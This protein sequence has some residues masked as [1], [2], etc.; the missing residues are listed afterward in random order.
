MI[1][2]LTGDAACADAARVGVTGLSNG[3]GMSAV[4]ACQAADLLAAAAPVA[5]GYSTLP[6]CDP[7]RPLPVLEI[8]GLRDGVVPYI[9]QVP[10]G[11]GAVGPYVDQW[12]VR[13][14]CPNPPRRSAPARNVL[15][16]RWA[17]ADGRVV[18]HDQVIDAEPR[19]AGR[20]LA[21]AVQLDAADLALHQRVPRR[22][23]R[24]D[25]RLGL[26]A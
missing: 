15:E 23:A 7:A 25:D 26:S 10:S 20:E 18:V 21:A 13:D 6:D 24:P 11:S 16:L 14:N 5:G 19:L 2:A 22:A 17:C 9:G 1:T 4:L 12:R 3:G 8:H